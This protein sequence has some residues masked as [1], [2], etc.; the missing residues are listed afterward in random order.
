[1]TLAILSAVLLSAELPVG[2]A[3]EPV[4]FSRRPGCACVWRNW[5]LVMDALAEV[6][7]AETA[8][9]LTCRSTNRSR[10]KSPRISGAGPTLP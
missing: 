8:E 6:C 4:A 3:P 9:L 2:S 5:T 1:M 7:G 10:R